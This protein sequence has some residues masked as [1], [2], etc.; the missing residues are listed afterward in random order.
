MTLCTMIVVVALSSSLDIAAI[1]LELGSK[2][3]YNHELRTVGLSNIVSGVL[4]G[5]T[6]SYIF[7]QSIFTLRAGIRSRVTGYVVAIVELI[8]VLLPFALTSY[9]PNFF[10]AS[11]LVM[12][13]VDLMVEWLWDVRHKITKAEYAVA[14]ST[15]L[16]MQVLG[17]EG[18]IIGGIFIFIVLY[19]MGYDMGTPD[20]NSVTPVSSVNSFASLIHLD[21]WTTESDESDSTL[22]SKG[23][24]VDTTYGSTTPVTVP[25]DDSNAAYYSNDAKSMVLSAV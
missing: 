3:D 1:E 17:V 9:V 23:M 13:C 14:L 4:G 25:A 18:G 2:L 8:S 19:I 11:L 16:L 5:Y 6:G 10:F 12:I 22:P 15:F 24:F 7:S 21:Q 20:P